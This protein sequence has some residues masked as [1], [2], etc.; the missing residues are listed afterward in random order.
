MT[1]TKI[2]VLV[3]GTLIALFLIAGPVKEANAAPFWP[4]KTAFNLTLKPALKLANKVLDK[5]VEIRLQAAEKALDAIYTLESQVY[6]QGYRDGKAG[7]APNNAYIASANQIIR[8]SLANVNRNLLLPY[9]NDWR[10]W[11]S[12]KS[13]I[14]VQGAI[15]KIN[16]I[17]NSYN[18]RTNYMNGYYEARR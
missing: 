15:K 6:N 2:K 18:A 7:K 13:R 16:T 12:P 14:E 5:A 9:L 8:N 10:S 3:M 17:L 4:I 11:Y 1:E